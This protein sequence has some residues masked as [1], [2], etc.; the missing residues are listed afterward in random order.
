MPDDVFDGLH[1]LADLD[2]TLNNLSALPPNAFED[3]GELRELS[4]WENRLTALPPGAFAGVDKL[5]RL[6][7]KKNPGTPFAIPIKLRQT[8]DTSYVLEA[9]LGTPVALVVSLSATGGTLFE[10]DSPGVISPE[11][12]LSIVL[13]AGS[14][15]GQRVSAV[16]DNGSEHV[17]VR[18]TLQRLPGDPPYEQMQGF[19]LV[20]E[21]GGQRVAP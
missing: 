4:L 3:L 8:D 7:L 14:T 15:G 12:V 10:S 5:V 11:R 6:N 19:E 13:P 20:G 2:L 16:L 21:A 18:L 1:R 17:D 9:P